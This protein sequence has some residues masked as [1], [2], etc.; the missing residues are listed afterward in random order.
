MSVI[1][2][3]K[4]NEYLDRW[5]IAH[6][7]KGFRYLMV[8]IRLLLDEKADRSAVMELYGQIGDICGTTGSLVER[9][10]RESIRNSKACGMPNREFFA[11]A[12]DT[13]IFAEEDENEI[14]KEGSL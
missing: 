3:S 7:N 11:R 10:I 5:A 9:G 4:I 6:A 12:V 14:V 1:T 8:G 13:L 2:N